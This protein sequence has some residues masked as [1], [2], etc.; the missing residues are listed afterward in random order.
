M[1]YFKDED[2][3]LFDIAKNFHIA[4]EDINTDNENKLILINPIE[5]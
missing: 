5:C 3:D 2:E 4:M 1:I